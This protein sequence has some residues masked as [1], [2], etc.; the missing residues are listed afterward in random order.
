MDLSKSIKKILHDIL[1]AAT[2]DISRGF[3]N[4]GEILESISKMPN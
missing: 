1:S 2:E 4:N 3:V